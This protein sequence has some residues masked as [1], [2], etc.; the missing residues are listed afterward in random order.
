VGV[1][2]EDFAAPPYLSGLEHLRLHARLH[3]VSRT[4]ARRAA[5]R[6]I[7]RVGLEARA[8]SRIHTYSLGMRRRLGVACALVMSPRLVILDEPTNGLDPQ[9]ISDLRSLIIEL[10]QAEG[11]TFFLSSHI[12]GEVEHLCG[13]VGILHGGR[14]AVQGTVK[15][16]TRMAR[17]RC[18]LR[19]EP[20]AKA[21]GL[22]RGLPWC[23]GLVAR[24]GSAVLR[25][26]DGPGAGRRTIE[27]EVE[28]EDV[29]RL[30][31][32]LVE[33][34]VDVHE[35]AAAAE[36]LESVFHREVSRANTAAGEAAG[37]A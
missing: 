9:G 25:P 18:R 26:G 10:N 19:V 13:R 8:Q 17:N 37:A 21:E 31:R 20:A 36:S 11:M 3:G 12:L 1:L 16:L 7:A 4:D 34:G 23:R 27:V 24:E 15:E 22:M 5:A 29:P 32:V 33:G 35:V 30:V 6:W 14:M 28:E 2:F